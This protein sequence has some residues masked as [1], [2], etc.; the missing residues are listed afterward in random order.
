MSHASTESREPKPHV[1]PVSVYLAVWG[2][3]L[4]LTVITVWISYFNFGV[5]NLLVAMAVASVKASLVVLFF[6]HLKYDEKFNAVVFTGCLAFLFTF[7][8]LT[9]ADTTERGKVDPLEAKVIQLVPARP[10]LMA[11]HGAGA[12]SL[13]HGAAA[14]ADS[15][16]GAPGADS[17]GGAG[18]GH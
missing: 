18:A 8:V 1:L 6:M 9:L 7:F 12:D 3:L 16:A 15:A 10:D 17:Q 14:P 4:V 2:G 11:G 13:S 5:M